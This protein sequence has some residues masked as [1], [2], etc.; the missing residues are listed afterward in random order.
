MSA[1]SDHATHRWRKFLRFSVRGLIVLVLVIGAAL[2]WFVRGARTQRDAVAAIER[3][4]GSD[5]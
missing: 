1:Q 5:G 4:G 3:A 2:G